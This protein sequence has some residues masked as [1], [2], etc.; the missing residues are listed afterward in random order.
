MYLAAE[1]ASG[2]LSGGLGSV[3]A[4]GDFWKGAE[5]GVIATAY[6][7]A[8]HGLYNKITLDGGP[9]D[10]KGKKK[11]KPTKTTPQSSNINKEDFNP[12]TAAWSTVGVLAADDVTGI[13]ALD[14]LAIPIV[15]AGAAAYDL[16]QRVY[17]TYILTH[18]SGKVYIGRASGFGSPY[19]VMMR[20][21][22][23]HHMRSKGYI[24]PV[25]DRAAQGFIGYSAIRGR[26]QQLIDSYGGVGSLSIGNRIR[27]VGRYNILGIK[28]HNDS[29]QYFGN[30]APYTGAF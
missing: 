18:P 8:V 6:N 16:S 14:D 15:L 4:G 13:G 21:Y 1:I 7:H 2:G 12:W 30:I 27:G 25:L 10:G 19:K 9:G 5:Q 29:N 11:G 28:F 26:E 3:I 24:N 20:R 23:G 17:V 22:Y